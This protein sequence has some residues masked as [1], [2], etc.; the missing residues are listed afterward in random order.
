MNY[1][2]RFFLTFSTHISGPSRTTGPHSYTY[3][4]RGGEAREQKKRDDST[5]R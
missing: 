3:D 5:E 1:Q 2:Q 4:V